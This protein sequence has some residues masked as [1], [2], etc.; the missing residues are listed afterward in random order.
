MRPL[1]GRGI[2][3]ANVLA[4]M[5]VVVACSG[6]G[7]GVSTNAGH[8]SA[9]AGS[10]LTQSQLWGIARSAARSDGDPSPTDVEAVKATHGEAMSLMY[11]GSPPH[12]FNGTVPDDTPVYVITMTGHFSAYGA[13][14][15]PSPP[16]ETAA[17]LPTGTHETLVI[18]MQGRGIDFSLRKPH[19]PE[20]D[21]AKAG[22]VMHLHQ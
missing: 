2:V 11:P 10:G 18:D 3:G 19:S 22:P 6:R 16:G 12:A 20:P 4:A 8:H 1:I 14:V 15:P 9:N 17:S 13:T 7:M 5:A 21:L